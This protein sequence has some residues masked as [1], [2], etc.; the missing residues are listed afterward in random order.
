MAQN[1]NLSNT[2]FLDI[3]TVSA[4]SS[5]EN[6]NPRLQKLWKKKAA[7][8]LRQ[9]VDELDEETVANAYR[10]RAAIYAEFGRIVCISVGFVFR[11]KDTNALNLRLLSFANRDEKEL[12]KSFSE[13]LDKCY[14]NPLKHRICGHNIKEFDIPYICRRMLV[15]S[16]R[17]PKLLDLSGKKPWETA[18][19]IDTLTMW[20]F[21]DYKHY[22]SLDLLTAVFDIPSPKDDIDGSQVGRV[23]YD[24]AQDEGLKRIAGYCEKDVEATARLY[25]RMSLIEEEIT[26]SE[27][28]TTWKT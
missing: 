14:N 16:L 18:H 7:N 10:D 19:L 28:K 2:L 12:L 11:D 22:T 27:S 21:G 9:P 4:V 24:E 25:M 20:K 5:Y 1:D 6:L 8:I 3:E 13:L 17:L 15:R 26:K 23:F